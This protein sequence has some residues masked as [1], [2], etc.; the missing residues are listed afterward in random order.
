LTASLERDLQKAFTE[1]ISEE[2]RGKTHGADLIVHIL[3]AVRPEQIAPEGAVEPDSEPA[4][5]DDGGAT[6][7]DD[8][9][10]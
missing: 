3:F 8:Q 6:S 2:H 5:T 1:Q 10:A 7:E 9:F 4:T